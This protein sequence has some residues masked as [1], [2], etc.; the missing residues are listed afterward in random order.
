M[1][2]PRHGPLIANLVAQLAF[3]LLA[4]TICIPSMQEW[5]AIFGSTQAAVQLTFSGYVVAYG[6][7]QLLYGPLSDRLGRKKILLLGIA[8]GGLGSLLAALATDLTLLTAARVLQGAGCAAGMV[9]GRAMV[10]DLFDGPERTRVMAYIGMA[11]GLVP[12]LAT[13]LGGQLHVRVGWQAN[14]VLLTVLSVV[15]FVAAWR[16]L[17]DHPARTE[18][19][20]THW[21]RDMASSYARLAREPSFL[22]YVALLSMT[23]ATFYAFLAG[24]PIVLGSY[25]VGPA[26]IGYHI[27]VVP[28][29]YIVGNYLT[30]HLVHRVGER[31]VMRVGQACA[32]VGIALMLALALAGVDTAL[33][34]SLPL[35]LLGLGH[36]L[37]VPPTLIGTVGLLPALAGAAAAVAGLMQQLMGAVGGFVVGL[38][39]H[40]GAVNLGWLMLA[41]SA[42]AAVSMALLQRPAPRPK[43][44]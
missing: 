9:V 17:P 34:L 41:L 2:S 30:T 29:S 16:G 14:F 27:M 4:M 22:L 15:M 25:G 26:G 3:G 44:L 36:G 11:M 8:L 40:D 39:P 6:G 37:L 33:A 35:L 13:I 31:R 1:S 24:A 23:T 5:G 28:L 7:L 43:A 20:Q 21:L 18:P 19:Q 12:P 32:L 38:V 42:S 10:Q